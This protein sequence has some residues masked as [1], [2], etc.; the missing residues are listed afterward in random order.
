M[1][2]KA[3][4]LI[5]LIGVAFQQMQDEH[6]LK[7]T[8]ELLDQIEREF[9]HEGMTFIKPPFAKEKPSLG[10]CT[11]PYI[12]QPHWIGQGCNKLG[13]CTG[14]FCGPHSMHQ[15]LTKF[16]IE[17]WD[18]YALASMAGTTEEY[19][20]DHDGMVAA[21][22]KIKQRKGVNINLQWTSFTSYGSTTAERFANIAK[23]IC[24]P[25]KD[26]IF[27]SQYRRRSGHYEVVRTIDVNT[28]IIE[29]LNSVGDA[30]EGGYLGYLE[31]RTFQEFADYIALKD[32]P[33]IGVVT[34]G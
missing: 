33:S 13:Q 1:S 3:V 24:Q 26:V 9:P 17:D 6:G 22:Q 30:Y 34:Y 8:K 10:Q 29:V 15:V 28:Q 31:N 32:A 12:S 19:G 25:N 20:T 7:P 16:D 2:S 27:H 21:F 11:N 23:I 14:W 4:I 18:E 5:L